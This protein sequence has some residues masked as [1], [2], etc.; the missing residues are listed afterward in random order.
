MSTT[1]ASIATPRNGVG[2]ATVLSTVGPATFFLVGATS[3]A[4]VYALEISTDGITFKP[5]AALLPGKPFTLADVPF[6]SCRMRVRGGEAS[7]SAVVGYTAAGSGSS[8]SSVTLAVALGGQPGPA[9]SMPDDQTA[10]KVLV[11]DGDFDGLLTLEGQI[12][13]G[14]FAPVMQV[15][16]KAIDDFSVSAFVFKGIFEQLR[17][18]FVG[19]GT[20]VI[21]VGSSIKTPSAG[22]DLNGEESVLFAGNVTRAYRLAIVGI[23]IGNSVVPQ[24]VL[25]PAGTYSKVTWNLNVTS[26]VFLDIALQVYKNGVLQSEV[27]IPGPLQSAGIDFAS[28]VLALDPPVEFDGSSDLMVVVFAGVMFGDG[29]TIFDMEGFA[30]IS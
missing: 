11:V 10:T 27:T 5:V 21:K 8:V 23:G 16:F 20:P 22:S 6:V 24:G 1:F 28:G 14:V 30:T 9:Q 26:G 29:E 15:H 17:A 18:R 2:A 4:P 7:A 12:S 3:A 13:N 25:V 19:R